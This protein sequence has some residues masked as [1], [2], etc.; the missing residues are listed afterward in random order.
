MTLA[1]VNVLPEPVM[2][3]QNLRLVAARQASTILLDRLG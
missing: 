2:P 1:I 3:K